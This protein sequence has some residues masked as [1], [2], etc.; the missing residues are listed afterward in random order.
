MFYTA[1]F[2]HIFLLTFFDQCDS[3]DAHSSTWGYAEGASDSYGPS[4]WGKVS[5]HCL[6][7]RQSPI[8]L[9]MNTAVPTIKFSSL[10]FL[11]YSEINATNTKLSNNGHSVKL[12]VLDRP[13]GSGLLSGGPLNQV[14]QFLQLHF[15][16]GS[17]D[18]QGS[19]HTL[20]GK[21]F[22]MEMHLVHK[23]SDVELVDSALNIPGGLSVAAFFWEVAPIDNPIL[24]DIIDSLPDIIE[25]NSETKLL[26][27][28][29]NVAALIKPAIS[30]PFFTYH[31]S[32]TTPGCNEVV[33]WI[34][35]KKPLQVS[36]SQLKEFRKL[37]D[38]HGLS[39]WDNF[40]ETQ[41]INMRKV[42][43]SK[44]N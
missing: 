44:G 15:H 28:K 4:Q 36:R 27:R 25:A 42:L 31:G 3:A 16:W 39:L 34:V 20:N 30:G 38:T 6:G 32:L 9:D 35:F 11:K 43:Y 2:S 14:Y 41:G 5:S 1:I 37:R 29:F 22:S 33:N 12:A 19:E 8:N 13:T 18:R 7:I 17:I 40:R 23:S 21:R 26:S 10:E 24:Q